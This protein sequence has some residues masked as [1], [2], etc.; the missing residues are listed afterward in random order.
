[1]K[2]SF[3]QFSNPRITHIEFTENMDFDESLFEG[4]N[5]SNSVSITPIDCEDNNMAQVQLTTKIGDDLDV[6]PFVL[7]ISA[8]AEFICDVERLE[9]FDDLLKINATSLLYSYI[10]PIV[11]LVTSQAGFT[12]LHL[13]L[14]NFVDN[15]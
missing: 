13:P 3:F 6:F 7:I 11:A 4:I 10:R 2:D 14:V 15:E 5:I 12:P 9:N 8:M 1:M